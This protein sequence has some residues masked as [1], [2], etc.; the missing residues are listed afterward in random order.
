MQ[1]LLQ[2]VTNKENMDKSWSEKWS[3]QCVAEQHALLEILFLLRYESPTLAAFGSTL[4]LLKVCFKYERLSLQDCGMNQPNA[5]FL[6]KE[7][8]EIVEKI[9]HLSALT[10]LVFIDGNFVIELRDGS[11]N[12]YHTFLRDLDDVVYRT[13]RIR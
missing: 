13:L 3:S 11:E 4:E 12:M 8:N 6:T 5:K 7:G 10:F 1:T 9:A 2:E